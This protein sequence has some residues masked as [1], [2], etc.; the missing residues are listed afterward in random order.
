L[1]PA[2][3]PE[4]WRSAF[5]TTLAASATGTGPARHS[6]LPSLSPTLETPLDEDQTETA[7]SPDTLRIAAR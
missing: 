6:I 5:V 7:H 2:T 4:N 3:T 1:A